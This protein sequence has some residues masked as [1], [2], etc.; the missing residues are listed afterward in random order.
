M[1]DSAPIS[2]DTL[3]H[4]IHERYERLSPHLQRIA[5]HALDDPNAFA[6]ETVATL[7][8]RTDVQPSTLI[9]FAKEFGYTGFSDMQKVFKLRLI[10]GAPAY[11]EQIFKHKRQFEEL[12]RDDPLAVLHEFC[13]ASVLC[14]E[15]LKSEINADDLRKAIEKLNA[16]E[17][18]Y[19]IGVRR[20]FPIAAYFSYGLMRLEKRC[21]LLDFVGGMVPQQV[22]TIRPTD[23]L[24]AVSFMEYAPAVVEVVHDAH[25]RGIPTLTITDVPSSPL[26]RHGSVCFTVD[27]ADVHQ[28]KPIAG[29][30]GLVQALIIALSY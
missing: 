11:R 24:V 21:Q 16:A 19:V 12:A 9:R 30:I 10:E 4:T 7:A 5:R 28:F 22:A 27:N 15:R 13:D 20:A 26:A 17:H 3:R 6:L 18:I 1:S 8:D 14:L 25:I 29:A 2:F 23:L